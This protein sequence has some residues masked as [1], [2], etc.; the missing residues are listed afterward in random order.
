MALGTE[1]AE[2]LQPMT[3]HVLRLSQERYERQQKAQLSEQVQLS[4]QESQKLNSPTTSAKKEEQKQELLAIKNHKEPV[5]GGVKGAMHQKVLKDDADE[6]S[7][8][9]LVLD[10]RG[11]HESRSPIID[12]PFVKE[13]QQTQT[14]PASKTSKDDAAV[15]TD[16]YELVKSRD[17]LTVTVADKETQVNHRVEPKR[18]D[19]N[20]TLTIQ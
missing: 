2:L 4:F 3:K 15:M 13:D 8:R 19:S 9:V 14:E 16:Q 11:K 7:K 18:R 20:A 12:L 6:L 1:A 5:E 10:R 17:L